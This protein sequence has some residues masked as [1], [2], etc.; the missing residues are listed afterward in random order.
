MELVQ[1][2]LALIFFHSSSL[3]SS[4]TSSAKPLRES[5]SHKPPFYKFLASVLQE[6][7]S[8]TVNIAVYF[9]LWNSIRNFTTS[10]GNIAGHTFTNKNCYY[11]ASANTCKYSL[12]LEGN[13]HWVILGKLFENSL[14]ML[15][16]KQF[17][18]KPF[19]C[20]KCLLRSHKTDVHSIL[21]LIETKI[22]SDIWNFASCLPFSWYSSNNISLKNIASSDKCLQKK[23]S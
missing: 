13:F 5:L 21:L 14:L 12:K 15:T 23:K 20:Y 3:N 2:L 19:L 22:Y 11:V 1:I 18:H 17:A 10:I 8:L 9:T 7:F 16:A 4:T 6:N